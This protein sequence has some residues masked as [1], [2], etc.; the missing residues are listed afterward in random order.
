MGSLHFLRAPINGALSLFFHRFSC[1][2][3]IHGVSDGRSATPW[4]WSAIIPTYRPMTFSARANEITVE[5][6]MMSV[7][8]L[9]LIGCLSF[10]WLNL[11]YSL[12]DSKEPCRPRD[13]LRL[14]DLGN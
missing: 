1:I 6:M 14:V 10:M 13:A 4:P 3:C 9:Q 8:V 7:M 11:L 2:M 5:A 12:L